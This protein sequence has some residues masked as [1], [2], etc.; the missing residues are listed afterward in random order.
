MINRPFLK[1][2]FSQ[3]NCSLS[4]ISKTRKRNL[5]L[6]PPRPCSTTNTQKSCFF[7]VPCSPYI[8]L[9]PVLVD[10]IYSHLEYLFFSITSM[11]NTRFL[12]LSSMV[13]K[14]IQASY[15]LNFLNSKKLCFHLCSYV[16]RLSLEP[17]GHLVYWSM[18]FRETKPIT[19][20]STER[21]LS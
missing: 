1:T 12:S 17:L 4:Y 8:P 9:S 19:C 21:D 5:C 16:A 15:W 6:F 11:I 7:A 14:L 10:I 13:L 3:G 20:K 18:F 2:F